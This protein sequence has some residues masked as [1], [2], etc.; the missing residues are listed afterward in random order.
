[1]KSFSTLQIAL[2]ASIAVHVVLLT[3]RFIDPERFNRVFQDTPLEVILVNAKSNEKPDFA[4]AI[5]QASLAGGGELEK[6]RATSP[7]PPSAL[8]ELGDAAEDAQ[9]KV[10]SMQEQQTQLLA[11]IKKQ[12]A[13][14]PPPDPNVPSNDPVR[15]E[16]E[17]K[18]K[19]LIKILAEI[20]KRINE[21][22]ARPKKR[23]IS[24]ATREEVYAL[25]YDE[26]RRKIEDK[27]T[28]NFPEQAG[29]K[30][31]G[32]LSMV[33]TVNFDGR[34]LDTEVIQTSGNLTLDRR[35]QNIVRGTGPFGKFDQVMRRQADQIVVVSRFKFTRDET[36]ETKLTNR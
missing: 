22:N 24:P 14:M 19:Q 26:L 28:V 20:E 1:M 5:A 9:R 34:V 32:E 36:L 35:A 3:V 17:Q 23:Y 11:Q 29:K 12:L 33:V 31:Y 21:E 27:G 6:G 4:K 7:L 16:R 10:D 2:G 30:L 13:S 18:R 15:A 8:M 25:Y